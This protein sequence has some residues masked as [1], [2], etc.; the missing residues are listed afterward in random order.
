MQDR[1][2]ST[3]LAAARK[4]W[5][6]DGRRVIGTALSGKAAD[7]LEQSSGIKSRTIASLLKSWRSGRSQLNKG[8]VLVVDEGGNG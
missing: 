8:D 5:E 3:M 2:K 1:G 7:G 4:S 6:L